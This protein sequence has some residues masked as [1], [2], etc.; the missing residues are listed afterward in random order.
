MA[1]PSTELRQNPL[2]DSISTPKP[3]KDDLGNSLSSYAPPNEKHP[4]FSMS[5]FFNKQPGR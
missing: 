2:Q 3:Y 4:T 5:H 1:Y